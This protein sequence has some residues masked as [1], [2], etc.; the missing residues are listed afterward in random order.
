MDAIMG[1]L[2]PIID[3]I[4]GLIN[5]GAEGGFDFQTIIDAISSLFGGIAG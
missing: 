3:T 5:G 1:I 2:Q 4:S